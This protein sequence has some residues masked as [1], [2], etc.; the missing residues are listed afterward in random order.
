MS[1]WDEMN[2]VCEFLICI[3]KTCVN[4]R[5]VNYFGLELGFNKRKTCVNYR[6]V[7]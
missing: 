6:L 5:L 1:C 4:Y 2:D 3:R 7:N